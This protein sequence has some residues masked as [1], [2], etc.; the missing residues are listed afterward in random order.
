MENKKLK[1]FY[2]GTMIFV[3]KFIQH[4]TFKNN[5]IKFFRDGNVKLSRKVI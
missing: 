3:Y 5:L 4:V 1:H 2:P